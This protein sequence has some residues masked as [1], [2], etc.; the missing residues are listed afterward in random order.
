ML[1]L[2]GI[3]G[4]SRNIPEPIPA[5]SSGPEAPVHIQEGRE[6]MCLAENRAEAQN[7]ADTYEI[8]LVSFA[9]GVAVFHT[10]ETPADVIRRGHENG[11]KE[12]S[13]NTG[14]KLK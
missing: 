13:V 10:E 4:C 9:Y 6:L 3:T 14:R 7:I 5:A 12:L 11:W 8:E 1:C 2:V